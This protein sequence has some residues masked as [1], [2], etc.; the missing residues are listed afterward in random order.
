MADTGKEIVLHTKFRFKPENTPDKYVTV[1]FE[2]SS[3]D[4]IVDAAI[5]GTAIAG[6]TT[7]TELL[8]KL[9]EMIQACAPKAIYDTAKSLK[10]KDLVLERG[11]FGIESD[12]LQIKIGDG[13]TPWNYLHYAVSGNDGNPEYVQVVSDD[14]S[15]IQTEDGGTVATLNLGALKAAYEAPTGAKAYVKINGFDS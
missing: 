6:E 5:G 4:I 12:T 3:G 14:Q 8:G 9:V 13:V 11:Q 2:S 1:H 7:L 10:K 15:Q